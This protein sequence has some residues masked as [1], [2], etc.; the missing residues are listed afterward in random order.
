M[1]ITVDINILISATFWYGASFNII[2]LVEENKLELVL[3]P[4]IIEEFEEVLNYEEIKTKID[5]KKLEIRITTTKI[6]E[7]ATII[8]PSRRVIVIRGD[9]D[10]NMILECGADGIVDYIIT[11]DNHLL[12]LKEYEGIPIVTPEEFLKNYKQNI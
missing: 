6:K 4:S 3:S 11:K 9:P 1:K 10:D 8:S 7:L 5:V 2:K 12:K